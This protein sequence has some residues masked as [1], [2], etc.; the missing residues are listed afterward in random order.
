MFY[1]CS[2]FDVNML[3]YYHFASNILKLSNVDL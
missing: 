2:V 3:N 1:V